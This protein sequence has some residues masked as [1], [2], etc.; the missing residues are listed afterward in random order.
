[1]TGSEK[2]IARILDQADAACE[3]VREEARTRAEA[4]R[5]Q[6]TRETEQTVAGRAAETDKEIARM[7]AAAESSAALLV[8]NARLRCRREEIGATLDEALASMR[9]MPEDAYFAALETL[10]RRHVRPGETGVLR[11][12]KQD[13]DRLPASFQAVMAELSVTLDPVP[14]ALCGGFVLAY[15]EIELDCA[16]EALLEDQRD[17]LEDLVNRVL[18]EQDPE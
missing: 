7:Q 3:T 5:E 8:R 14:A 15:G 16:F 4:L 1:M 18:F 11:L 12:S 13:H 9:S 10:L 6:M 17:R 2:I